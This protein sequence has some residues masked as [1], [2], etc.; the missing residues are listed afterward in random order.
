MVD[1]FAKSIAQYFVKNKHSDS[2]R[3]QCRCAFSR[4]PTYTRAASFI[5]A[6]Y[7]II[8]SMLNISF[9]IFLSRSKYFIK[10]KA[11]GGIRSSPKKFCWII[12]AE[13]TI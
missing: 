13:N 4:L 1:I 9:C 12:R 7:P 5:Y 2:L 3:H 6:F 10:L 8:N 11:V